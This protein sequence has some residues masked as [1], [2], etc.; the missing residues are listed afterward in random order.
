MFPLGEGHH[1]VPTGGGAS[2]CSHLGRGITMF[3]L[4]EWH[5]HVPTGGGALPCIMSYSD[6]MHL[7]TPRRHPGHVM[8]L[9]KPKVYMVQMFH[10]FHAALAMHHYVF[11]G[12]ITS[13]VGFLSMDKGI[14]SGQPYIIVYM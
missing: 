4:G 11:S 12:Y 10:C 13:D 2:P 14:I 5:Y 3:P 7:A 1:Q 8:R 9:S 6:Q